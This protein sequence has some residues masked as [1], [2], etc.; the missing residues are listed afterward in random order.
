MNKFVGFL[1][2]LKAL[3]Y[4]MF[5]ATNATILNIFGKGK[6]ESYLRK[7]TGSAAK[8]LMTATGATFT[9]NGLENIDPSKN[10]VFTGNHRSYTDILVLFMIGGE[11]NCQ[12][13]FMAK[14]ELFKIP[15]LGSSMKAMHVISVDRGST[16]KAMKS[17]IKAIETV[18]EG[19]RNLIIFPE[20]TRSN[21]GHTLSP[22]KKGAFTIAKKAE[23]DIMP[24]TLEGTE[25]YM[26]KKGFGMYKANI[27]ITF[28]P[29]IS[30]KD[31]TDM[32]VMQETENLIK[33]ELCQ[34]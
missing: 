26:P 27:T 25:I 4:V 24:F 1:R 15:F 8:K 20:G 5:Y 12:F 9:I 14:K 30:T 6:G 17:I 33:E 22:F 16:S 7:R 34:K 19:S 31:K 13:T 3:F 32:E 10:Y 21:D 2:F 29:A 18:K 11:A 28:F 23:V